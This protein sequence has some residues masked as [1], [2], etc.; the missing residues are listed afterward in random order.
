MG[1]ILF[2]TPFR[3]LFSI[4]VFFAMARFSRISIVN[5]GFLSP[6]SPS[7]PASLRPWRADW[8]A[9]VARG[10]DSEEPFFLLLTN[11]VLQSFCDPTFFWHPPPLDS[12][13]SLPRLLFQHFHQ[14]YFTPYSI[15]KKY[16]VFNDILLL[17]YTC[18]HLRRHLEA[19]V[20][21]MERWSV[22]IS[23]NVGCVKG[24]LLLVLS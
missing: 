21:I 5:I 17:N 11:Q 18:E 1:A 3:L 23:W 10:I 6:A 22:P 7:L 24:A 13:G 20:V 12:R 4:A 15:R 14:M 2:A 19:K 9:N 8:A 16:W